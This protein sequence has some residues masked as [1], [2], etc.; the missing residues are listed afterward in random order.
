MSKY[1]YVFKHFD[2]N[3]TATTIDYGDHVLLPLFIIKYVLKTDT[4]HFVESQPLVCDTIFL[5]EKYRFVFMK[6]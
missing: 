6:I 5:V 1:M 2:Y 4:Y 3:T